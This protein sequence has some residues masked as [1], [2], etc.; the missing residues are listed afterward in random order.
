[1]THTYPNLSLCKRKLSEQL[2]GFNIMNTV[3]LCLKKMNLLKLTD[4]YRLQTS[5]YV[6]SF[7]KNLLPKPLSDL[8]IV[9]KNKNKHN[10]R[11][12]TTLKLQTCKTRTIVASKSIKGMGPQI[13][14]Y[15]LKTFNI[16]NTQQTL[17]TVPGFSSQFRRVTVRGYSSE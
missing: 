9:S 3:S 16:L 15:L 7:L 14:N 5:K 4:I 11:H 13:W 2:P 8:F 17:I 12:C 10:T 1:M 6:L